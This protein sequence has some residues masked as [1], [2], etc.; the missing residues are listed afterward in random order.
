M[1]ALLTVLVTWISIQSGLPAD[2]GHPEVRFVSVA[3]MAQIRH[4][5]MT[6]HSPSVSDP[7]VDHDVQAIYDDSGRTIYLPSG[8]T[9][10]SPADVS[11]LVHE[12]TH[13]L[14]NLGGLE[15]D[16]SGA[17]EHAAYH[18]QARWLE[19]VGTSLAEEFDID[20]MTLLVR[21]NCL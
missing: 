13:H 8:W 16:C 17:R 11:L 14:Q 5:R 3:E 15:Y 7:G 20:A 6:S 1:Q 10:V 19:G 12:L 4:A 9:A 21:T 2:Y 18:A